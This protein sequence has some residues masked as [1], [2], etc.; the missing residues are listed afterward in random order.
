MFNYRLRSH[1]ATLVLLSFV[2]ALLL[3]IAGSARTR[4]EDPKVALDQDKKEKN[5]DDK[6]KVSKEEREYQKI[7]KFGLDLY[8]KEA[9]FRDAVE[10]AYLQKQREH[11]DGGHGVFTW[12][13]LEGLRGAADVNKDHVVTAEELFNYVSNH[14][15]QETK[16][17]QNPRAL[18]WTTKDFPL[19]LVTK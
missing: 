11:S 6:P 7:K 5:K 16:S 12:E 9:D 1:L 18:A 19:A 3:P 10:T 17:R 2:F 13:L 4:V 15:S 14:V 8:L